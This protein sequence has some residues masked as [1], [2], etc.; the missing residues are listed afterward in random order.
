[1]IEPYLEGA[2][3][4]A[5]GGVDDEDPVAVTEQWQAFGESVLPIGCFAGLLCG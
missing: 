2:R 3:T 4:L 1:M 5:S